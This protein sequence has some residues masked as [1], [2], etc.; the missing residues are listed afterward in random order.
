MS[1]DSLFREVD[2]EVRLEQYQKL[3]NRY[4]NYVIAL[5]AV[6]ILGV[7][8]FK[9]F[10]YW[11]IK[12]SEEAGLAFF[13]AL[14]TAAGEKPEEGI[15]QLSFVTQK[16]FKTLA[17]LRSAAMLAKNGKIDDAQ[18]IYSEVIGDVT[19]DPPL[20]DVAAIRAAYLQVDTMTAVELKS[21]LIRFDETGNP[22]RNAFR[23]IIGLAAYRTED[24]VTADKMMNEI[25]ADPEAPANMRQR[26]QTM[27]GLLTPRLPKT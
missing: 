16:G 17:Q 13:N 12:Q 27:I 4:G 22:W 9:A 18:K 5:C 6:V 20:R 2:E 21:R 1:D 10:Q 3:W 23:E 26:A 15:Q 7:A 24:F 19:A 8:G 14:K 11:Q 25:A